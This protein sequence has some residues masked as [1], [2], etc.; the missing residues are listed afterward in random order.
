MRIPTPTNRTTFEAVGVFKAKPEG[1]VQMMGLEEISEAIRRLDGDSQ[2]ELLRKLP[3][4]LNLG[5]EDRDWLRLTELSF[6]FWDN[7]EDEIYNE[8]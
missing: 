8:L 4:L 1:D 3:E 5:K 2:R 7:P 6:R